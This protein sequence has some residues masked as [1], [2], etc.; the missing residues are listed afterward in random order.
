MRFAP[1][2]SSPPN[3]IGINL[4]SANFGRQ[5][6][7]TMNACVGPARPGEAYA[8]MRAAPAA[9]RSARGHIY[10]CTHAC[11]ACRRFMEK[12]SFFAHPCSSCSARI[13]NS[14][15]IRIH[16][17]APHHVLA[18]ETAAQVK[19]ERATLAFSKKASTRIKF[20]PRAKVRLS[21]NL[22]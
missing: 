8:G 6:D 2:A 3:A 14:C 19:T 20:K 17:N 12:T 13:C 1:Q 22:P 21:K 9:A 16:N 7:G 18:M 15:S 4:S 11:H 5:Y 10:T